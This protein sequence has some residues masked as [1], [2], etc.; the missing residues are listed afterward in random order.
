MNLKGK[1]WETLY[2][3]LA[4]LSGLATI[5]EFA[6]NGWTAAAGFSFFGFLFFGAL[7]SFLRH[8]RRTA[9]FK[10]VYPGWQEMDF[11]EPRSSARRRG[12]PVER[13]RHGLRAED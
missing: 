9:E 8:T 7:S 1:V 13:K 6:R 11:A 10:A 3:G 2:L 4:A 12:N 5:H